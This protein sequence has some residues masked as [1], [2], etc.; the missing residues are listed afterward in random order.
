M[1]LLLMACSGKRSLDTGLDDISEFPQDLQTYAQ[2][3]GP[4]A[5][6]LDTTAQA[7][8]YRKFKQRFFS[9]WEMKKTSIKKR[10]I[11]PIFRQ[12]RGYREGSQLWTQREWDAMARNADLKHFPNRAEP[13]ITLRNTDLREM[14]THQYR[15]SEPT[16]DPKKNPFDYFQYSRLHVGM[17]LF[18]AHI[19]R[20]GRWYFVE[21]ALAAGWVDAGDVAPVDATFMER[22]RSMSM[23]AIVRDKVPLPG[24]GTGVTDGVAHI[25]AVLPLKGQDAAGCWQVLLPLRGRDGRAQE[26]DTILAAADAAPHPLPMTPSRVAALGNVMMGQ[27]Y[28]W[29]GMF[30]L[31]DCS[32]LTRDIMTPF[33][34]WL[35]RNS[36][37][38][39]RQGHVVPLDGLSPKAKENIILSQGVPFLSLVGMRGHITLYV[40]AH[41]GRPAIFHDFWGVRIVDGTD[42]NARFVVGRTVVTSITP[43]MELR[44][45]YRDMTFVDRLS[46]LSTPGGQ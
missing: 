22:W 8:Q 5:I 1:A 15:F 2:A 40:G 26:G 21:S 41:D 38:Q 25:G 33:G 35:P 45:L 6:L 9:T 19:S 31:R 37:A 20:D 34:I 11:V 13:A 16:P 14:P 36:V 30:D 27:P 46:T 39:A 17:P 23:A 29:G 28:G 24:I 18:I 10:E 42:T 32:A 4:D 44:N 12:A 3:A 43:G 7:E